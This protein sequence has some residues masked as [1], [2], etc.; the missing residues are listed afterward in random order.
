MTLTRYYYL[1][2]FSKDIDPEDK[3]DTSFKALS[4]S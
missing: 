4:M 3:A 2:P 1:Q